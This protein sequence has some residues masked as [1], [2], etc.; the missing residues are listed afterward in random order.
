MARE[1][2]RGGGYLKNLASADL[3]ELVRLP[4]LSCLA[5]A[6]APLLGPHGAAAVYGPQKGAGLQ[7]IAV[8]EE[9]LSRLACMLGGD[10]DHPG[11]GAAGGCGYGLAAVY[12]ATLLPGARELAAIA[13]LPAALEGADLVVTGE[14]KVRRDLD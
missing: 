12:G 3:S 14:G 1:L 13:G 8:L 7:D 9:G 6:R 2:P 5:D 11:A 4:E 10:P